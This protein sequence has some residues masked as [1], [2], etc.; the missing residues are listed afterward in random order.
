MPA[1]FAYSILIGAALVFLM[2]IGI[3]LAGSL[4]PDDLVM[5]EAG[6]LRGYFPTETSLQ[7]YRDVFER[8]PFLRYLFNSVFIT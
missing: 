7:N 4:K 5:L 6:S 1:L 2:P 3:M 8:V